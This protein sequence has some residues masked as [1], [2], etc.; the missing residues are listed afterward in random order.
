MISHDYQGGYVQ[1]SYFLSGVGREYDQGVLDQPL[2]T[3]WELTSRYSQ[4][5]MQRENKQ[6]KIYSVGVNY[7]VNP[8]IK[9]MADVIKAVCYRCFIM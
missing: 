9:L 1:L 2:K 7:Y 3:G 5:D 8:Q 6:A 4:F